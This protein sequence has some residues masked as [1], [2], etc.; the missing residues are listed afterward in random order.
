MMSSSQSA[1]KTKRKV[2]SL[3]LGVEELKCKNGCGYY[4]NPEWQGY[5]SKCHR[6]LHQK[7]KHESKLSAKKS[8]KNAAESQDSSLSLAFS[9]FEEKKKQQT[10]KRTKTIKSI[11]KRGNTLKENPTQSSVKEIRQRSEG[12][13]SCKEFLDFMKNH[14]DPGADLR[15][16]LQSQCE[17]M[18]KHSDKSIDDRSELMQDFYHM[19]S[20]KFETSAPYQGMT[21]EQVE[22]LMDLVEKTLMT[23]YLYRSVFQQ[24]SSEYEE[25][26]LALQNRIRNLN[27]VTPQHLDTEIN[28]NHP[29]VRELI[30]KAIT[31]IIEMD[32]KRSPQEKLSCIVNCSKNIFN[33]LHICRGSPASADEFLPAM[34]YIVLKAN[35]PLLQSNIKFVTSY[36]IPTRL[37]SGEGGYYFTNLCCAVAFIENLSE[38]SL[39]MSKEEYERYLSGEAVPPGV[40]D[41]T[42][43]MSEDLRLIY[44]NLARLADLQDKH[45]KLIEDAMSLRHEINKSQETARLEISQIEESTFHAVPYTV[46]ADL[47]ISLV[48][49][50]LRSSVVQETPADEILV[51]IDNGGENVS[52][53]AVSV[54]G[55]KSVSGLSTTLIR[56]S[57]GGQDPSPC[58]SP[59]DVP[60]PPSVSAENPLTLQPVKVVLAET[61]SDAA[62][63][64]KPIQPC[65]TCESP[66]T[67]ISDEFLSHSLRSQDFSTSPIQPLDGYKDLAQPSNVSEL[68]RSPMVLDIS[69]PS[70]TSQ[71]PLDPLSPGADSLE[72]NLNLPPPLQP[73][74]LQSTSGAE[75]QGKS[76]EQGDNNTD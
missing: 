37:M 33:I 25:K 74:V 22:T 6:D 56:K 27:W 69:T 38:E 4:G 45:T 35:P 2:N 71:F 55:Q 63:L 21:P 53:S 60:L 72:E 14:P 12:F 15:K 10:E 75:P 62:I 47:D 50:F 68:P 9:K 46:P 49:Y 16:E 52:G 61:V 5:C 58:S 3:H 65:T 30:D 76:S 70:T 29:E 8:P 64:Q 40:S 44:Q 26:D 43:T 19:I 28:E 39:N 24:I 31:D 32:S 66:K 42:A 41:Q 34:V 54:M 1:R 7:T 67:V 73:I 51:E 36:S 17:K 23:S 18:R 57:E 48:P 11:I 20:N 13:L 59:K